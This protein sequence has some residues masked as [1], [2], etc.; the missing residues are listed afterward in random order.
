MTRLPPP[1]P[2]SRYTTTSNPSVNQSQTRH[3]K[4]ELQ[5][6]EEHEYIERKKKRSNGPFWLESSVFKE[7]SIF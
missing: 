6:T 5:K 1:P 7:L 2:Q 3:P 4:P